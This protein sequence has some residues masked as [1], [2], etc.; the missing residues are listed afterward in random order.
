M[1]YRL[2]FIY[3]LLSS[4]VWAGSVLKLLLSY[5]TPLSRSELPKSQKNP[6]LFLLPLT[7]AVP[8]LET[9]G[10]S[11]APARWPRHQMERRKQALGHPGLWLCKRNALCESPAHYTAAPCRGH[12]KAA[13]NYALGEQTGFCFLIWS[14]GSTERSV[15]GNAHWLCVCHMKG[16]AVGW[17]AESLRFAKWCLFQD[18]VSARVLRW[19]CLYLLLTMRC[20]KR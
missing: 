18:P 1:L 12:C 9:L 10:S 11:S 7:R 16:W 8:H 4:L 17:K 14:P 3:R 20:W 15:R 6:S 2:L 13:V 19:M 5:M